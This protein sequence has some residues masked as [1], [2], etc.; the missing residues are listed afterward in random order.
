[1]TTS[2]QPSVRPILPGLRFFACRRVRILLRVTSLQGSPDSVVPHSIGGPTFEYTGILPSRSWKRS[3]E[4]SIRYYE[5]IER[6][7]S[8]PPRHPTARKPPAPEDKTV[9]EALLAHLQPLIEDGLLHAV[10]RPIKSG[11]EAIVYL[12][13]ADPSLNVRFVAAKV[14]RPLEMRSFKHDSVYQQG[15]SRGNRPDARVLRALGKKSRRGQTHK[16]NAWIVHEMKTLEILHAA[17]GDVPEPYARRGPVILMEYF[18]DARQPAPVLVNTPL[19]A[20][21]ASPLYDRV[22]G[23]VELFL[24]HNRVHAD[25]SAYNMLYWEKNLTIIDFPQSVD[26]RYNEDAFDLLVRDVRNVNAFFAGT[27]IDVVD[28]G[29]HALSLWKRNVDE[30]R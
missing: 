6:I 19:S 14:Y 16:F 17:G 1:M 18:G 21:D 5:E 22:L 12:C 20:L 29:E 25:L 26:P 15:R 30:H 7:D 13:Q 3:K 27:G 28:P 9:E 23:N 11:K 10:V 4:D 24:Q 2:V 8:R